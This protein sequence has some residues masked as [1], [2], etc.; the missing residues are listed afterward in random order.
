MNPDPHTCTAGSLPTKPSL[1]SGC[2]VLR[3]GIILQ[4][5]VGFELPQ[6]LECRNYTRAPL[7]AHPGVF[8]AE[9]LLE[10]KFLERRDLALTQIS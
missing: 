2:E 9:Y 4:P 3:R 10:N 5:Q 8:T 6:P 7:V 1:Q